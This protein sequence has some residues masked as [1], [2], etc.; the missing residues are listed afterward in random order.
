MAGPM[1]FR[2][3]RLAHACGA[4]SAA[5]SELRR[6]RTGLS[7][8]ITCRVGSSTG[9]KLARRYGGMG[10]SPRKRR[11]GREARRALELLAS[12]RHGANE[13]LLVHG[14][15]FKRQM[16]AGLVRAGLAAAEREVV[17]AGGKTIEISRIRITKVGRQAIEG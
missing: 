17:K 1:T 6:D 4:P 5:I 10:K 12:S 2:C 16:L 7:G 8:G 9:E 14:H 13:E 15:G 3:H 11:L